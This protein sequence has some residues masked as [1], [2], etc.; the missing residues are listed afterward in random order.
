VTIEL[1]TGDWIQ[2]VTALAAAA[3]AI[4]A[5]WQ[6]RM[7]KQQMDATLRPWIGVTE[8]G[9]ELD[10]LDN[11]TFI[12][13]YK[14]F[15][16]VPASKVKTKLAIRKSTFTKEE[17]R[18]RPYPSNIQNMVLF[19]DNLKTDT[20][21]FEDPTIYETRAQGK[22]LY[23]GFMVEYQYGNKRHAEMIYIARLDPQNTRASIVDEWSI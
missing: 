5:I 3:A 19:P 9:I 12:V 6:S 13:P 18:T 11:K 15:G 10:K 4:V 22:P 2:I 20:T 7:T 14:N 17:L 23:L 16:K 8:R 1:T 21:T